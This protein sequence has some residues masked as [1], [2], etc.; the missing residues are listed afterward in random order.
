MRVDP[1]ASSSAQPLLFLILLGA[2]GMN[3]VILTPASPSA[4]LHYV[5]IY[6]GSVSKLIQMSK[7]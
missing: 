5:R 4:R 3:D 2:E 1:V 7:F 6:I